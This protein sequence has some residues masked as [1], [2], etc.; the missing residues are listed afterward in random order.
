MRLISLIGFPDDIA[1]ELM[2]QLARQGCRTARYRRADELQDEPAAV[3]ICADR[4]GW[5]ETIC[6]LRATWSR[7][8]LVAVTRAPDHE[9]WLDALDAGANDYC[10]MPLDSRQFAWLLRREPQKQRDETAQAG[11]ASS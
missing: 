1:E 4:P 3:F 9:K 5:L 6:E 11:A 2:S 7:I 8:F 10:A